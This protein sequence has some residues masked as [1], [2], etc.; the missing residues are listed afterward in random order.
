MSFYWYFRMGSHK[1]VDTSLFRR[2]IWLYI[3]SL[4]GVRYDDY[5]YNQIKQVI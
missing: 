1:D 5:D 4:F 2:A 3:Q